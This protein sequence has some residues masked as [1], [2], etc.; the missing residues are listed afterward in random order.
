MVAYFHHD[1]A[2]NFHSSDHKMGIL[3]A[4]RNRIHVLIGYNTWRNSIHTR[5]YD[6]RLWIDLGWG[7]STYPLV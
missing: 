7:D 5:G 2:C 4:C 3:P 1:T 6:I